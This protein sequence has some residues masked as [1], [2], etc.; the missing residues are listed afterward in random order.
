MLFKYVPIGELKCSLINEQNV[1]ILSA[2][3]TGGYHGCTN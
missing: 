2:P 3:F 1:W